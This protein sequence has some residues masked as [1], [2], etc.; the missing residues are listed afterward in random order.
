[1]ELLV[2]RID[3]ARA[4]EDDDDMEFLVGVSFDQYLFEAAIYFGGEQGSD[5]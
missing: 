3:V 4:V 2:E 5:G 1:M